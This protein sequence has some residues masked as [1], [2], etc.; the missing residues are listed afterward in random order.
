MNHVVP[1]QIRQIQKLLARIDSLENRVRELERE[2][3]ARDMMDME[4]TERGE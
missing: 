4:R 1:A 2:R 3:D